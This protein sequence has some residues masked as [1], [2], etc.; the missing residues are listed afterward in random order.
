MLIN[1]VK[2]QKQNYK[3]AQFVE[4]SVKLS[5]ATKWL[6]ERKYVARKREHV[7]DRKVSVTPESPCKMIRLRLVIIINLNLKG[8]KPTDNL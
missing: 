7:R 1:R 8:R 2:P 6:I 3:A 4:R 5:G